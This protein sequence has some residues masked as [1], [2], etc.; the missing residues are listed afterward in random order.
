MYKRCKNQQ[1]FV[2]FFS[3]RGKGLKIITYGYEFLLHNGII[4]G[5]KRFFFFGDRLSFFY[6]SLAMHLI[7]SITLAND[8]L[9][10][11]IF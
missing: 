4:S 11:Q 3:P 1:H 10:T 2:S 7:V 6:V 5:V 8:Q 9:D